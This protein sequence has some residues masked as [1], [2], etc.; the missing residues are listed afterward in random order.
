MTMTTILI[1][2]CIAFWSGVLLGVLVHS[3]CMAAAR[4]D[5]MMNQHEI[6]RA[7]NDLATLHSTGI[8]VRRRG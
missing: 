5:A 7:H 4:A 3:L 2:L 6:D 1:T 8:E